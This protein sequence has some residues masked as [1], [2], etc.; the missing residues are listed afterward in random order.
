[1]KRTSLCV[2]AV[3]ASCAMLA[4]CGKKTGE[5]TTPSDS[6][7]AP[8]VT[9]A[10]TL[11]PY[12]AN[13]LTGEQKTDTYPEGQRIT[14]V[15]VNNI[16]QARP[17]RGLSDAQMLFEIKVEGGIT[18][19]MAVYNDYKSIQ[20]IGPIRSGRDQFFQLIL[21]WQ[22]LY[23]HEGQ[24][25][26][27]QQFGIDYEYGALNNNDGANGYRNYDRVNYAGASYNNGTLPLEHT[28]YTSGENI[29]KYIES[30]GADMNRTYNSTFFNFVDYRQDAK[31]RELTDGTDAQFVSIT[32]SDNGYKTR[33][34][35]D[36]ATKTY[37]MQQ[38]YSTDGA[39]RDTVDEGNA[40]QLAFTNVITLYTDIYA[41]PQYREK[42]LQYVEYSWGGV[43]YYCYG[44]KCEKI[45]WQKGTPLEALRLYYLD[46]N[47][48]CSENF[49][50]V[51]TGKSY[52]AVVDV[53]E[54]E[55]FVASTLDGVDLNKK[56]SGVK[57]KVVADADAQSGDSLGMS[58]NDLIANAKGSGSSGSTGTSNNAG[59]TDTASKATS[60]ANSGGSSGAGSD[61][62]IAP[63]SQAQPETQ[64][65]SQ[66][67]PESQ[68]E[69]Q[70]EPESQAQPDSQPA[71][72][73]GGALVG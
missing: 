62:N 5:T 36:D 26:V 21:P 70:V 31:T 4:A 44:G 47:G 41:Y 59:S 17:Q 68:P 27:M 22:A 52:V 43:G 23:V 34:V 56:D 57:E 60:T 38:Y 8:V 3:L 32:H 11:P 6:G 33:F 39:W 63:E 42:D 20:E 61:A 53:D 66:A 55:R 72:D 30:S 7:A 35:Y 29:G 69:S 58:T 50:E 13:V 25:V 46:E 12:E 1:M 37:S 65:E 64:P 54:A 18:R 15:M 73:D 14:A 48:Q 51:N 24:S 10:P 9:P 28:M 67:Q 16:T 49:V 19:F 40:Q 71:A 2:L 45:Y